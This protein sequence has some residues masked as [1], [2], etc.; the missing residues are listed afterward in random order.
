MCRSPGGRRRGWCEVMVNEKR[1]SKAMWAEDNLNEM[2][3][4]DD[5]HAIQQ[6]MKLR[7]WREFKL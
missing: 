2:Y 6:N 5:V 1:G 3:V 7:A 4:G